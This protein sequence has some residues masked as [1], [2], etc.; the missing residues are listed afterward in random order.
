LDQRKLISEEMT[1]DRQLEVYKFQK[2]PTCKI[3][4]GTAGACREGLTLTAATHVVF[5][6]TEW[7]PA[8]V[9]QSY[10]RAHR[11]GQKNAV[12]VHYLVCINT[13]DEFVQKV[14]N[15]KE[16]MIQ[17]MLDNGVAAL[18]QQKARDLILELIGV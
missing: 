11:I 16:M 10:S 7:S 12:T 14:L 13:I 1:S 5:L 9:E 15:R 2:D 8:Y 4:L 18:E 3:F 6:D 17:S